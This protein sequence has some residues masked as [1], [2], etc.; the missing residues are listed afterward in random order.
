MWVVIMYHITGRA[1][2]CDYEEHTYIEFLN[3]AKKIPLKWS[4]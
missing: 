3:P 2:G 1:L 4:I